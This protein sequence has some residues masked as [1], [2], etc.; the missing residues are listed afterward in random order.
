[1]RVEKVDL[2]S[3]GIPPAVRIE[4]L[5]DEVERTGRFE[6]VVYRTPNDVP[7][8]IDPD[9]AADPRGFKWEFGQSERGESAAFWGAAKQYGNVLLS[10]WS[11][12][13]ERDGRLVRL[14]ELLSRPLADE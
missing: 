13:K 9:E 14:D 6:I 11:P 7:V 5:P 12:S 8:T 3:Y 1:L 4:P 10:W 2:T